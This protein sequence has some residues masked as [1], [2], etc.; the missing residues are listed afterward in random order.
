LLDEVNITVHRDRSQG[1]A[2]LVLRW[3]GGALSKLTTPPSASHQRSAPMRTPSARS[4]A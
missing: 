3:K 1:H 4:A 2:G